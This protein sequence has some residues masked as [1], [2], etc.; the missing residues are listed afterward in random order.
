MNGLQNGRTTC[1]NHFISRTVKYRRIG[2]WECFRNDQVHPQRAHRGEGVSRI[3]GRIKEDGGFSMDRKI[4]FDYLRVEWI[5]TNGTTRQASISPSALHM[6]I[7]HP[8][9]LSGISLHLRIHVVATVCMTGRCSVRCD[10]CTNS[11]CCSTT[12]DI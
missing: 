4:L 1:S 7:P 6:F 8:E 2:F 12:T 10:G 5:Y 9:K 11:P 3:V